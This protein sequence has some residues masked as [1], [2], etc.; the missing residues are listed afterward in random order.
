MAG[1]VAIIDTSL[2]CCWLKVPGHQTAGSEPDRWD[3]DR[4]SKEIKSALEAD[5]QLVFPLTTLIETGNHISHASNLRFET[6]KNFADILRKASQGE[7]P[8]TPFSEQFATVGEHSLSSIVEEW[9]KAAARGL[10]LGDFLIT[11]V[12]DYYSLASFEVKILTSDSELRSHI[13]AKPQ[14]LPRRR[15]R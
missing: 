6:A 9:P 3:Y 7:E 11:T 13:P 1:R 2:M 12:A 14:K 4:T 15:D 10:S 5:F 8:W